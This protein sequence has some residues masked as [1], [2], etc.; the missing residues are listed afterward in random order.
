MSQSFMNFAK[1]KALLFDLDG[2]I[3]DSY[4]VH[5]EI[6]Q[7][8]MARFNIRIDEKT[9][10]ETYSPDWYQSYRKLE[11]PPEHWQAADACW[12]AEA[13]KYQPGLLPG[14][15]ATLKALTPFYRMGI[16]TSGSRSRILRDINEHNLAN[17]FETVI[18]GDDIH[19]PKPLPRD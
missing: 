17:F 16:V 11:L 13:Q 1:V 15:T 6:F 2:T 10:T 4:P 14:V 5:L 7:T 9:F 19:Q 12:L 18:T 3:L 8:T